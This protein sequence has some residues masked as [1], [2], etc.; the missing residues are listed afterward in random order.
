MR[1]YP[2]AVSGERVTLPG[3]PQQHQGNSSTS[4]W[5]MLLMPLMSSVAM[6]GYMISY[7]KP[8]LIAVGILFVVGSVGAGLAMRYQMRNSSRTTRDRQRVRYL[9]HL[10]EVRQEARRVAA[11]QRL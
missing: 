9:K 7:G 2:P 6:A 8:L 4:T 5:M 3:V 11:A 10:A 1:A